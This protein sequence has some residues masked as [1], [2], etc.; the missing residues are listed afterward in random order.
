MSVSPMF[1]VRFYPQ[2]GYPERVDENR[3]TFALCHIGVVSQV[4]Y[5]AGIFPARETWIIIH[6]YMDNGY[7]GK[8]VKCAA[9]CVPEIARG[10]SG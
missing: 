8:G 4:I 6:G 9:S 3:A 1:C 10:T 7:G 5:S 2:D